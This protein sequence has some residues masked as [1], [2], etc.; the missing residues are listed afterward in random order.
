MQAAKVI[1]CFILTDT[2]FREIKEVNENPVSAHGV[3]GRV[4]RPFENVTFWTCEVYIVKLKQAKILQ[5][6]ISIILTRVR[7]IDLEKH[8]LIKLGYGSFRS[9]N[10]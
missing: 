4:G 2:S 10:Y 8:N 7:I 9:E 1:I 5:L 3:V 6:K